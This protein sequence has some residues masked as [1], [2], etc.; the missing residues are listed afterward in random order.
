MR[1]INSKYLL[2]AAKFEQ[3]QYIDFP[4]I[5]FIGRSNV[6]KS[7]LINTLLNRRNLAQ[8]SKKPGK[9]RS[10]NLFE[11]KC[12]D[13][14]GG[15]SKMIFADLPGYGFSNI[16]KRTRKNWEDLI[17]D[18]ILKRNNLCSFIIII[19]IRH[20]ADKKDLLALKWIES[21]RKNYL[22]VATKC[23]KL[24][25]SKINIQLNT[26]EKEFAMGVEKKIY[27]FSSKSN[28][29]KNLILRWIEEQTNNF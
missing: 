12:F 26:L 24:S 5:A 7:S 11:I 16:S 17:N 15:K 27:A 20:K 10:I 13:N 28:I 3:L 4:E 6:G 14:H 2:S 19:D 21:F 8:I 18:Y 22:V 9:T 23:D 25:K 29:G 1:I